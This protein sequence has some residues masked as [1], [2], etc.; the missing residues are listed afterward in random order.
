MCIVGD[1]LAIVSSVLG[2]CLC[3]SLGGC[4]CGLCL[5]CFPV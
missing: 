2:L 4:V 3:M 1:V 5:V